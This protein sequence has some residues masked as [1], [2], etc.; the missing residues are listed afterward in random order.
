MNGD[1]LGLSYKLSP[2]SIYGAG[3]VHPILNVW[4]VGG[5]P[6]NNTHLLAS[7]YRRVPDNLDS[8]LIH[9]GSPLYDDVS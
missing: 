4:A 7:I 9:T 3:V 5:V 8:K 1:V 2:R 6:Q